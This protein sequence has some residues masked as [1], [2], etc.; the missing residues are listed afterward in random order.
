MARLWAITGATGLVGNNLVRRLCAAGEHVRVLSRGAQ[1]RELA[2]LPV[3]T[4]VGELEPAPLA[5]LVAGADVVVHAAAN[6]WI[7]TTGRREAE[8]VNVLGTVAVCDA[9]ADAGRR[10]RLVHVSSVDALGLGTRERP[11]TETTPPRPSEG[12]VPYVD[13]KRAADAAVR[14]AIGR[15]LDAV[16][17]HPTFMIGPWDWRPSSG[18]MVLEVARGRALVAPSGGNNFVDVRDVVT[19]IERV[20]DRGVAGR[21]SAWILGHENLSYREAWTRMARVVGAFAPVAET[22]RWVGHAVASLLEVPIALGIP[23]GAIN[24][25]TTRMSFLPHYFDA[26]LATRELGLTWR[27]LEVATADAWA[28]FQAHGYR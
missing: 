12:G 20:A 6:V 28:W 21:G 15:G 2:G 23:E 19:G 18:R 4:V 8:R 27:P 17:V 9:I 24:P 25:A 1:R 16:I 14:A 11:A 7:G 13:T 3:E 22:P 10:A 26:G 5:Q